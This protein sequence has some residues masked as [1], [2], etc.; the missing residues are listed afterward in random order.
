MPK[1]N[2]KRYKNNKLYKPKPKRLKVIT[3][4]DEHRLLRDEEAKSKYIQTRGS[5]GE[6]TGTGGGTGGGGT[7]GY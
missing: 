3:E 6:R 2:I 1:K 5:S 7:G 4:L